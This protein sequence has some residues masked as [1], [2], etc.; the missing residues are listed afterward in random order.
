[1]L[2]SQLHP[3]RKLPNAME[4]PQK[5]Y[6]TDRILLKT[7]LPFI[8]HSITPNHVTALRF[9]L[10]PFVVALLVLDYYTIGIVVFFITALT[11]AIDG[12]MARTRDQITDWG[13]L[14]DPVA[15]KLLVGSVMLTV[16]L[17]RLDVRLVAAVVALEL[18]IIIMGLLKKRQGHIIQANV[19][20]K[21]KMN[22]QCFALGFLLLSMITGGHWGSQ[23]AT[24][25]FIFGLGF[26]IMS[27]VRYGI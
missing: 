5:I 11:D 9:F 8:P 3:L 10:T 26:G 14:Y 20:G 1:M 24:T 19:W 12:A 2:I 25:L 4:Q 6:F 13:K 23:V 18:F 21:I 15:D 17:G 7:I 27:I 22:L 16:M